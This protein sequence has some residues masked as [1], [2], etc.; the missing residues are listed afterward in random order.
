MTVEAY[1]TVQPHRK[2]TVLAEVKGRII[3]QSPNLDAGGILKENDILLKIDPTDYIDAVEQARAQVENAEFNLVQEKGKK[4]IAEKEWQLIE[5]SLKEGGIGKNLAL[6]IPHVREKES[7]L[8]ASM[9]KLEK[10]LVD[11]KRTILRAP[12]NSLVLEEFV[13]VGQVLSPQSQV[14]V[15]VST[16]EYRILVNVPY[17]DLS[18]IRVP[19]NNGQE[20]TPVTVIQELGD[21]K[22]LKRNGSILRFMGN[23]DPTGRLAQV[24]VVVK[25][26]LGLEKKEQKEKEI[27]LLIGTYVKVEIEGPVLTNVVQLPRSAVREGNKV[28]V[29]NSK[30]RLEIRDI[31]VLSA[32]KETAIVDGSLKDGEEVITSSLPVA[33]QGMELK[34]NSI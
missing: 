33:I 31:K 20:G 15:L 2:L 28:W 1:G 4:V 7:A 23:L 19:Q 21:G 16:D 6:R 8:Q 34:V 22:I 5:P 24:M 18:W 13:E 3:E 17:D 32:T 14:A 30:G 10:A 29:R 11:L 9:S 27:P 25:D 12:F 26:P